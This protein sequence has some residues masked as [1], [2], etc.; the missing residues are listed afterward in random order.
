[1]ENQ[2]NDKTNIERA[3][4]YASV[5]LEE[6]RRLKEIAEKTNTTKSALISQWINERYEKLK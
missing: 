1:M 3:I 4:I 5:T 6:R 2:A